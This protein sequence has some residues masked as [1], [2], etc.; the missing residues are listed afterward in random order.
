MA[1]EA[2]AW[3]N[4]L[5]EQGKAENTLAAYG[6]DIW[7]TLNELAV[8]ADQRLALGDLA[9]LGQPEIDGLVAAWR[10]GGATTSTI[11]R[12]LSALRS[13][14][15]YVTD[16]GLADG[17]GILA[18]VLPQAEKA[19][20]TG[21]G[22]TAFRR[23]VDLQPGRGPNPT[24]TDLR[25]LAL[26]L[27]Q[28]E[29]G[30]TTGEI[31][32]LDLSD[33]PTPER[34][35]IPIRKTHLAKRDLA[36]SETTIQ[37]LGRYL[38]ARPG[39]P[40]PGDPLFMGARGDRLKPRL[41]QLSLQDIRGVAGL[42]EQLTVRAVRHALAERMKAEGQSVEAVARQ[43]GLSVTAAAR[44]FG[45]DKRRKSAGVRPLKG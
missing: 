17:K 41:V 2:R 5:A 3:L 7:Y 13:F 10:G 22:S 39:T 35:I 40:Q 15:R 34:P 31:V 33:R 4:G 30:M 24:W 20:G 27:L 8:V 12:R 26:V 28:S 29:T 23:L 1:V 25:D 18:A 44:Y 32:A 37:A 9:R 6:R 21:C 36:V 11:L 14:A 42:R 19:A 45:T 16:A 38:E 43:L